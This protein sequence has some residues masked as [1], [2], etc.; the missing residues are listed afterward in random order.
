MMF[1][2]SLEQNFQKIPLKLKKNSSSDVQL[3]HT[4]INHTNRFDAVKPSETLNY[5]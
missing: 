1:L 5:G 4:N 3:Y 2:T